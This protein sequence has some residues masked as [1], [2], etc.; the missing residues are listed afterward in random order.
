MA[1][2]EVTYPFQHTLI[3]SGASDSKLPH[4]PEDVIWGMQIK[5]I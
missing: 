4:I 3:L 2:S 1:Y 5:F